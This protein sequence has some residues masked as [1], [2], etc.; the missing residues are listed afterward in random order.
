M[1]N[2]G[3]KAPTS[4]MKLQD[5]LAKCNDNLTVNIYDNGFMVEI[6]GRNNDDDWV[7]AKIVCNSLDEVMDI[8]T[9][10]TKIPKE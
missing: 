10:A 6:S 2:K 4:K 9:E 7:T 1:S 8:I 3:A 5:K